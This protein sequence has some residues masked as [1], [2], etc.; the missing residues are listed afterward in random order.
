[1]YPKQFDEILSQENIEQ[2]QALVFN[3][4]SGALVA[5][6]IGSHLD[7]VNTKYCLSLIHI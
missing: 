7:K 6:M 5:K 3:K 1:M 2:E 4:L